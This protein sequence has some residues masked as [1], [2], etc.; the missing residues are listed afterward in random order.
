[1]NISKKFLPCNCTKKECPYFTSCDMLPTEVIR[2]QGREGI[3][4]LI[5]GQG[6]GKEES[7][8]KRCFVGRSGKYMRSI[9]K[10][11]WDKG[12]IFNLALTNNV[13]FHPMDPYG[14]DREPL[15]E[16]I[17]RCVTHLVNDINTLNPKAIIP[18][19]KNAT[20]TFQNF[21]TTS[22]TVLRGKPFE[23][24]QLD[25]RLCIPTWHPAYLARQYGKYNPDGNN[26]YDKEFISDIL[27]ALELGS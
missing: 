14:K 23:L 4:I 3:D 2:H 16:E 20:N 11:I 8:L 22:M 26:Q 21:G 18:V 1:M 10:N 12:Q 9:I 7:K 13:R 15:P 17:S 6:S 27:L 24:F 5:F 19:G 25:N